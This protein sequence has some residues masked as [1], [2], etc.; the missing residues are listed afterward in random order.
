MDFNTTNESQIRNTFKLDS[1]GQLYAPTWLKLHTIKKSEDHIKLTKGERNVD[2]RRTKDGK[3]VDRDAPEIPRKLELE[4]DWLLK[5]ISTL[6]FSC[7]FDSLF[8]FLR[9]RLSTL[10]FFALCSFH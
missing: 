6:Y 4:M 1:C 8:D 9:F 7:V 2:K 5:Y 3:W 10:R